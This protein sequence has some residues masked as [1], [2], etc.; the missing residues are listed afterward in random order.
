M[1]P[2]GKSWEEYRKFVVEKLDTHT[3]HFGEIFKRL[4]KIEVDL[5]KLKIKAGVWGL[6]AGAIPVAIT[7]IVW[8]VIKR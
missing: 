6:L 5:A 7:I 3:D 1:P 2:N 4:N 8:I